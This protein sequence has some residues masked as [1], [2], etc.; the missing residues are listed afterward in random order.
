MPEKVSIKDKS[1]SKDSNGIKDNRALKLSYSSPADPQSNQDILLSG[2]SK[3][4][5]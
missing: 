5:K 1:K 2:S 3:F 4:N